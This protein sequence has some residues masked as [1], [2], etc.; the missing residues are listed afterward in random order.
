MGTDGEGD[1]G[2][3]HTVTDPSAG[4]SRPTRDDGPPLTIP[5]RFLAAGTRV[6][7]AYT[8]E[9]VIGEGGMGIV[10]RG[11]DHARG[12]PVALK[13]LHAS[14]M[15]DAGIRRRF[16]REARVMTTWTHPNVVSVYDFVEHDDLLAIVME[17][18]EGPTLEQYLDKWGGQLPYPDIGL[19]FRGVL[20]AMAEAHERGVVHRDLKPQNILLSPDE[21]GLNPRVVDFGIAKVLD[22][23]SYTVTGALLGSCKYMSPEQVQTLESLDHRSDIYS[24][25]VSMYRAVTGRCPFE[26][27]NHFNL[28]MAHVTQVP[29]PPSV[30]RPRVPAK[31]EELILSALSKDRAHRPQSCRDMLERLDAALDEVTPARM[32]RSNRTDLPEVITEKDGTELVLVP[33]G[34]FQMGPQRREVFVDPFYLARL[35]VTNRQFK[36]FIDVTGYAPT[37]DGRR[38]LAHWRRG[39]CPPALLDHP[40]V[41][42][43]WRDARA[44]CLWAGMRLPSEAE[45]EKAA[46]GT[47]GRKYPWGRTE[48]TTAHAHFGR[49]ATGTQPVLGSPEGAS[50]YGV[51]DLAGNAG[52]WCEDVD[53]PS[54][55]L[56]GPERNPRNTVQPTAGDKAAPRVVRGGGW[57]FDAHS[58]RTFSRSSYGDDFRVDV[59]GFRCAL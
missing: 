25:G 32:S 57:M 18:V 50:I 37:G 11:M 27:T 49:T 51:L 17:L 40:V 12:R 48:P 59:V 45:W 41:F 42:V 43:S 9:H 20:E 31:L 55:Y 3:D 52:E 13:T 35:P 29:E 33:G 23:T 44:Y 15:G 26:G 38:F 28:M 56:S 30:Y 21:N 5:R 53:D 1:E 7:D 46:R 39:V 16:T 54:F 6:S 19:V 34:A 22:G 47:D 8:I 58:L 36:V 24:L 14:L 10:Y 2:H 4:D